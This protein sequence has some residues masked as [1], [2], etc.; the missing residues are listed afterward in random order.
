MSPP[1]DIDDGAAPRPV[2]TVV[3]ARWVVPM[4]PDESVVL[5][6]HSVV[7]DSGK[8]V[9][10]IPSSSV[11]SFFAAR[12]V[13]DR[14]HSVV[15][16][17][18]V[19]AHTHTGMSLMRGMADDQALMPWLQETVWPVESAFTSSPGFTEDGAA[20]AACEM[21]RGGITTFCDMYWF[22]EGCVKASMRVGLRAL[23]GLIVI[24]FPSSY[25][26][27]IDAYLARGHEVWAK[28]RGEAT[29]HFAYAP[30]APYTVPDA[31]WERIRDLS[32]ANGLMI[33]TH[34]HET[35]GECAAS[36]ALDRSDSACHQS[37]YA[38]RPLANFDRMGLLNERLICAHMT[39]LT[40]E[41]VALCAERGVKVVHCPCSN[42]KLASGFC[43]CDKLLA[44][45]VTVGLG[46]D[47]AAS[48][49]KLDLFGEMRMAALMAKNVAGDPTVLPAPQALRMATRGGAEA[50]GLEDV[51]GSLK[52]G[53]AADLVV[54]DLETHAGNTPVFDVHSA[55]VYAAERTDVTDVFVEGRWVVKGRKLVQVDEEE[56][57]GKARAWAKTISEK[58]PSKRTVGQNFASAKANGN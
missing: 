50:L 52:C 39:Q 30:H 13:V 1:S 9:T 2:D 7:I 14:P 40:H 15:M 48:N 21:A 22:P 44:A 32:V 16:P 47:S 51:T 55:I 27:D 34:M 58:F 20:L 23:I 12:E 56:V 45:G 3:H 6:F 54:I 46:T 33:H 49:N 36:A 43:R 29:M 4:E 25:A 11:A 42:A 28:Y 31:A 37:D 10:V 8:I 38:L 19:N 53:K 41:E 26:S 18:M 24:G 35:A 57:I 17:G 5:P